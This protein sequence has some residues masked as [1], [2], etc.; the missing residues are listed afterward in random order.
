MKKEANEVLTAFLKL[1][2]E[3]KHKVFNSIAVERARSNE[4][5]FKEL[6]YSAVV[7]LNNLLEEFPNIRIKTYSDE[8]GGMVMNQLYALAPDDI[9]K[10]KRKNE[11]PGG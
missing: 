2:E 4:Q 5:R 7:A 6:R 3:D 9:V 11:R 10:E 8:Y 1:T